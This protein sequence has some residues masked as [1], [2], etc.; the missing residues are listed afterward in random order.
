MILNYWVV[1]EKL[2]KINQNI[3]N[4]FEE[5][6]TQTYLVFQPMNKYLKVDSS[7]YVS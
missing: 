4:Y 1:I 2:R 6:G 3:I 7:D 5:D